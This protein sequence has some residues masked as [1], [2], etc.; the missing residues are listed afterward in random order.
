MESIQP[1]EPVTRVACINHPQVPAAQPCDQ[2]RRPF[3]ANCLVELQGRQ[4]CGACKETVLRDMQRRG[5]TADRDGHDAMVMSIVG[6]LCFGLILEPMAL[7]K[8]IKALQRHN[9]D[10]SL[11]DRWKAIT[12]ISIASVALLINVGLLILRIVLM[13]SR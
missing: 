8:G 1:I 2:C 12:A 11:P 5:T 4:I 13:T 7:Y 6:I 9:Q 3:C 10:P